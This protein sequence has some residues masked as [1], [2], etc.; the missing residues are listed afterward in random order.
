MAQKTSSG[1][2]LYSILKQAWEDNE[3]L[4]I[5]KVWSRALEAESQ[6]SNDIAEK[7]GY[8]VELIN[9]VRNDVKSLVITNTDKFLKPLEK[10]QVFIMKNNLLD[11]TSWKNIKNSISEETLELI[12]ACGDLII[13]QTKGMNEISLEELGELHHQ[14]RNLIDEISV[15]DIEENVKSFFINELMKIEA[16]ILN[17]KI[18]GS[19]GLTKAS[20]E[21]TGKIVKFSMLTGLFKEHTTKIINVLISID[22]AAK[23]YEVGHKVINGFTEVINRLPPGHSG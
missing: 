17:Y 20:D 14:V 16:A 18:R 23:G 22:K 5:I 2:K 7:L 4:A 19:S 6:D 9:D 10:I 8:L 1:K 11:N 13:S 15:S 12:D 21:T 3:D